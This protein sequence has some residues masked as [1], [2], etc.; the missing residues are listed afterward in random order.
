VP[1]A[2]RS[3]V[4]AHLS[5]PH[6]SSLCRARP[7]DLLNKRILGYLSW[8]AHRRA[9]HRSEVLAAMVRD[10]RSTRPHHIV[11]TGDLTQLGLPSEF[12]QAA[13][14]LADL[15]PPE[16]VT[17]VPGNH[18]AYVRTTEQRTLGLWHSY[19]CSDPC[20]LSARDGRRT[21]RFPILRGRGPVALIGLSSARPTPPFFATGSLGRAQ[22]QELDRLLVETRRRGLL[23]VVLLHHP[24][25]PGTVSWRRR[26]TDAAALDGVL[27][28][29]GAELVLH[30]H[31]HRSVFGKILTA[32]GE[33]PV[34][35]VPSASGIG[36]KPGR[37]AQYHLYRLRRDRNGWNLS[38]SV[39][40][41][42]P[43]EECFVYEGERPLPMPTSG[44]GDHSP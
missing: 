29:R 33:A 3:F 20:E 32:S 36:R 34:I 2:N 15:A 5:D 38:V 12:E 30:G 1:C 16:R 10:L 25:L 39:R 22:L 31:A 28:R 19:A 13:R 35:G 14:W 9:E 7:S 27:A 8:H 4:L 11:V 18:D 24:P 42:H 41:Y 26:L 21:T 6:L 37:R 43:A 17:V 40:G 23:R 44:R